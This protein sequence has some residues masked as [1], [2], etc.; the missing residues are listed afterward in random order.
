MS[1]QLTHITFVKKE[2]HE[3]QHGEIAQRDGYSDWWFLGCP[4][5]DGVDNLGDHHVTQNEQGITVSPSILC[6]CGAHYF[7]EQNKIRWC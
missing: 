3:L 2:I 1:E 6:G 5:C 7:V 4:S